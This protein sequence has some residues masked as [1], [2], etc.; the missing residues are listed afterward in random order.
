MTYTKFQIFMKICLTL[1]VKIVNS[2]LR[3]AI[4]SF[5]DHTI[6]KFFN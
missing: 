6:L 5:E 2:A 1:K 3:A 4:D